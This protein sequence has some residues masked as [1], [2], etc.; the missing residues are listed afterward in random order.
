[1]S[2]TSW[3]IQKAVVFALF[4][5]ELKT[6][7][8][9]YKGGY[10]WLLI[11]PLIHVI[12]LSLIFGYIRQREMFGIDV[13]VFL[14]VGVV[15]FLLFKNVALRVMDGVDANRGLFNYRQIKPT[16]T[17]IARA[18]L[19]AVISMVVFIIALGGMAW[20]G[21]DVSV[22][23]PLTVIFVYLMLVPAGLGLGMVFCVATHYMP[24][25]KTV[26]RLTMM[27]LYLT[28]GVIFPVSSLPKEFLPYLLWN[29]MLHVIE[30]LHGSFF[31]VYHTVS[32]I[33]ALYPALAGL[34]VLA[35]GYAW[36][37]T[38]R[39]DLLTQ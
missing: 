15:P 8:G 31:A 17:F 1:M 21:M 33:N 24:E 4:I 7:G 28:S 13:P 9:T 6:R 39:Y 16:D 38:H 22:H 32:G 14:V 30:L 37:W 25:S 35:F 19:D 20:L 27:P 5:R 29:P 11:E 18:L 3:Q 34:T 36:Y 26:V 23:D 2:R 10:I 12:V